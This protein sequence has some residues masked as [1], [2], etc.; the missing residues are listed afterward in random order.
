MKPFDDN[1]FI[2]AVRDALG[3]PVTSVTDKGPPDG[4]HFNAEASLLVWRPQGVIDEN[5]VTR[6]IAYVGD[7]EL[8]RKEP[9]NRF[10]D[11]QQAEAVDL[12]FRY[13]FRVSLYRR[14]S[15]RGPAIQSA[16]LAP[17]GALARYGKTHALLTQGSPIN[18]RIFEE[19]EE[20]AKWLGLPADLLI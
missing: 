1:K 15:Y 14:F 2:A 11:G 17:D 7:L 18:V 20:A 3:G 4:V 10:L 19:R 9:F 13:I 8:R 16:I 5:A 12:N 6:I